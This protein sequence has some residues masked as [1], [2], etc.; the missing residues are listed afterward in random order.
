MSKYFPYFFFRI[1]LQQKSPSIT[2][3]ITEISV[4]FPVFTAAEVGLFSVGLI[5]RDARC[6]Y[7]SWLR[8]CATNRN[9]VGSIPDNIIGNIN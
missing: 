1:N 9:V 3:R 7:H 5:W 6:W 4:S 8:H 2:S